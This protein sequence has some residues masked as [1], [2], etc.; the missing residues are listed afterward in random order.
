MKTNSAARWVGNL[1][2][3]TVWLAIL[4]QG[5]ATGS[6][7]LHRL[8]DLRN[9]SDSGRL[10]KT[11]AFDLGDLIPLDLPSLERIAFVFPDAAEFIRQPA[12][13]QFVFRHPG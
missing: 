9:A 8:R 13:A 7:R 1:G 4:T 3:S 6:C 10:R 5:A 11:Q 12:F 2:L